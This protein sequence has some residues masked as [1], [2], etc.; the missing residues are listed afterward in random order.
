MLYEF[1]LWD[2]AP[3]VFLYIICF[4]FMFYKKRGGWY[5]FL[6]LFLFSSIRYKVGYDY[7]QYLSIILGEDEIGYMRLELLP[8]LIIDFSRIINFPQLF[9]I[10]NSFVFLYPL[11]FISKRESKNVSFSMFLVLLLPFLFFESLSIVRNASAYSLVF[12]GLFFFRK[13]KKIKA[14]IFFSIA[15][16]FHTSAFIFPLL[17]FMLNFKINRKMAIF[18][19]SLSFLFILLPINHFILEII[20]NIDF[21]SDN[22]SQSYLVNTKEQG[23]FLKYIIPISYLPFLFFWD[24]LKDV[25]DYLNLGLLGV[26]LW[27]GLSFDHTLSL[28][29]STFCLIGFIILIPE[30]FTLDR[31]IWKINEK[32]LNLSLVFYSFL[33]FSQIIVNVLGYIPSINSKISFLPYQTIFYFVEYLNY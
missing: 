21:I 6:F 19:W 9:F 1:K 10:V 22:I 14:F 23:R 16:F 30:V 17:L 28:R 29:L 15:V 4:F 3:Y 31:L 20:S 11:Y 18:I 13:R 12:L 2:I 8:R 27:S 5:I 24:D 7:S 33:F 25:K 26:L 32:V